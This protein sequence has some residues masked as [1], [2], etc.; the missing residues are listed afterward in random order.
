MSVKKV[1]NARSV[2]VIGASC[3]ERKRGYQALKGLVESKYEGSIYPVNPRESII[4]GHRCYRSVL[5]IDDSVDLALITTP[6]ETLEP[7]TS[8]RPLREQFTMLDIAGR[9]MTASP[10]QLGA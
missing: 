6:A 3:N 4:L 1:L 10:S 9:A 5:D 7:I 8:T 2:A